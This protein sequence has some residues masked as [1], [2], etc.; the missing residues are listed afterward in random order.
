MLITISTDIP[1]GPSYK[2]DTAN[3]I[4][5]FSDPNNRDFS[6]YNKLNGKA[7]KSDKL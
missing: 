5:W 3:P 6:Y 1:Q 4:T 2:I 7:T